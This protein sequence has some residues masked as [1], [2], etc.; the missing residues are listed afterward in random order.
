MENYSIGN[1]SR[2][3]KFYTVYEGIDIQ[4][5]AKVWIKKLNENFYYTKGFSIRFDTWAEVL[6][7][8]DH[9][10]IV[11]YLDFQKELKDFFIVTEF[12]NPN[13]LDNYL[14]NNSLELTSIKHIFLQILDAFE[15]FHSLGLYDCIFAPSQIHILDNDNIII[16]D[17][18]LNRL[19]FENCF[20]YKDRYLKNL[21]L[22]SPELLK[23]EK[24]D[25][26]TD[27][28]SLGL[29]LYTLIEGKSPYDK[30]KSKDEII[31][32]IINQDFPLPQRT[33][34]FNEII[35]KATAKKAT[36][37]YQ[38]INEL[39]Q[40][41]E[42]INLPEHKTPQI[43]QPQQEEFVTKQ[44]QIETSSEQQFITSK[45]KPKKR[46]SKFKTITRAIFLIILLVL[47]VLLILALENKLNQPINY[48]NYLIISAPH[49]IQVYNFYNKIFLTA[50][51]DSGLYYMT[52]D[53]TDTILADEYLPLKSINI[54]DL[55]F[56]DGIFYLAG[57]KTLTYNSPIPALLL[58]YKTYYEP[59]YDVDFSGSYLNICIEHDK[60]YL[61]KKGFL[62]DTL[63]IIRRLADMSL[64]K[65]LKF[66]STATKGNT[67]LK[68]TVLGKNI[69]LTLHNGSNRITTIAL[70]TT[71]A[72]QIWTHSF[73]IKQHQIAPKTIISSNGKLY[74][75]T[76]DKSKL[77]VIRQ[78]SQNGLVDSLKIPLPH[79]VYNLQTLLVDTNAY[80]V[81]LQTSKQNLILKISPEGKIL[82]KLD[83]A[84][85][86]KITFYD[87]TKLPDNRLLIVG[88]S[89]NKTL[90]ILN[91]MDI[92]ELK[93]LKINALTG[94]YP[95]QTLWQLFRKFLHRKKSNSTK[96]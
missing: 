8:L 90:S 22:A 31:D 78:F 80:F 11:K 56:K 6:V 14:K 70:D 53:T 76:I 71:E 50:V 44:K 34:L 10:K 33:E 51:D 42:K 83:L 86:K 46:K 36:G 41:F 29:L 39:K 32:A 75:A 30:L 94:N 87:M 63:Q 74:I 23:N 67:P 55:T 24:T 52:L 73:T 5:A 9:P 96:K 65:K 48:N 45:T 28:Y 59:Y 35:I 16:E 1:L 25:L 69:L 66:T 60:L 85:T 93:T 79:K 15:H 61:L 40:E 37:R 84:A 4:N 68:M 92:Y 54:N 49:Q 20:T 95:K 38:S 81:L 3:E 77:L 7:K 12:F 43:Q 91:Q 13:P 57:N 21:K 18:G 2:F 82:W 27:I 47:D 88:S 19:L 72:K 58:L 64:D 89:F 26:R 17:L 62:S